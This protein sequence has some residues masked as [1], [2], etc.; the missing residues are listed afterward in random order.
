M[1]KH[2]LSAALIAN[3]LSWPAVASASDPSWRAAITDNGWTRFREYEDLVM[4]ARPPQHLPSGNAI[5]WVRVELPSLSA[6]TLTEYDCAGGGDRIVRHSI[7]PQA[8]LMG[9]PT[10]KPGPF[11]WTY[12]QPDTIGELKYTAACQLLK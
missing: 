3:C 7:Y 6:A 8:N 10:I 2:I 1:L 12:P 4:F 5:M 9:L 11:E